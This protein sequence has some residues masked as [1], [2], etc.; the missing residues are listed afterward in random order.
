MGEEKQESFTA[1]GAQVTEAR[2]FDRS[3]DFPGCFQEDALVLR[4]LD[5][6]MF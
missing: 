4:M 6:L 2:Q 1:R 5:V 3:W